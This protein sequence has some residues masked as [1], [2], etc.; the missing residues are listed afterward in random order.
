MKSLVQ[1]HL[2]VLLEGI[3]EY[4]DSIDYIKVVFGQQKNGTPIKECV[5][6]P[7]GS[8]D[9]SR[10]GD[11][12]LIP[13][14]RADTAKFR[15]GYLFYMDIRPTLVSGDDLEIAPVEMVMNWTLFQEEQEDGEG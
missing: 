9:I 13:W 2:P 6:M 12:I 4:W 8:G 10:N 1:T 7:D 3:T 11:T 14:T 15:E 5:W